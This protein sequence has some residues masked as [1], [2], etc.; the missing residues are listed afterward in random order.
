VSYTRCLCQDLVG[1]AWGRFQIIEERGAAG[2]PWSIGAYDNVFSE[3]SPSKF[4]LPH[5]AA[6]AEFARPL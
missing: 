6:N 5:L 1:R 2:W 3:Q 4:W